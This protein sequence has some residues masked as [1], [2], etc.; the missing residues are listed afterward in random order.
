MT[1]K[2]K[3]EYQ[4]SAGR[5]DW[6]QVRP[7]EFLSPLPLDECVRRLREKRTIGRSKAN[8]LDVYIS[9]ETPGSYRF[10]LERTVV[11]DDFQRG[12]RKQVYRV[13]GKLTY[14]DDESTLVY[15]QPDS[16]ATILL[17]SIFGILFLMLVSSLV[18]GVK[19]A[20]LSLVMILFVVGG[21]LFAVFLNAHEHRRLVTMVDDMLRTPIFY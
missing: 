9:Q 18:V 12:Q 7:V 13:R 4:E 8:R 5:F 6:L 3:R 15:C 19:M 17:F 2:R 1:T 20:L 11:H 14:W 10:L 21:L 16:R